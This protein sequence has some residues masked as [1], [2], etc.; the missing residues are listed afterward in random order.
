MAVETILV[1]GGSGFVGRHLVNHLVGAGYRV[2][3]PT[4]RRER[5]RHLILLPTGNVVEADAADPPT[6]DRLTKR[7]GAVVNLVGILNEH[8]TR[9][10]QRVHVELART[11]VA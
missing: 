6:L 9:S 5:A 8:S 4:R 3:V 7:A 2:I 1:L 11:V 10:F